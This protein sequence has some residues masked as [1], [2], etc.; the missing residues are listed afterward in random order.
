MSRHTIAKKIGKGHQKQW[1]RLQGLI[2]AKE[3]EEK[4][5]PIN[6]LIMDEDATTLPKIAAAVQHSVIKWSDINHVR[7]HLGTSLFALQKEHRQSLPNATITW[8]QKCFSYAVAQNK[9]SPEKVEAALR[10]IVSHAFGE[11]D[12]C[13]GW[14]QY[15]SDP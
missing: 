6:V 4:G 1:S 2:L 11:H 12:K 13:G 9:G 8:L 14:C 7:K 3:I 5:L 10:S 15:K